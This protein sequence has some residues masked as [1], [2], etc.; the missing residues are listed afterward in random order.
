MAQQEKSEDCPAKSELDIDLV[1]ALY[2]AAGE[3]SAFEGLAQ[4]LKERY[5]FGQAGQNDQLPKA[6]DRQLGTIQEMMQLQA[7][8]P[9]ADPLE[10]AVE[11]VPTPSVVLDPYGKVILTNEGGEGLFQLRPG[12]RFPPDLIDPRYRSQFNSFVASARL[13]GNRRRIVVRLDPQALNL[14][15]H[16]AFPLELA[17][18][19]IIESPKRDNG[20]IALRTMDI[21]WVKTINS[22]LAETFGLTGAEAEVSRDFYHLRDTRTVAEKRGTSLATVQTQLKSIYGK[23]QTAN[24]AE[25]LQMLSLLC[26]RASLDKRSK[27]AAWSNP[28]GREASFIR[29]DGREIAYSWQG[30]EHG[31]PVAVIHGQSMGHIF[32]EEADR[33]YHD[34]GIKLWILSRPGF[35]HSE[36][37]PDIPTMDDHAAAITEFYDHLSIRGAPALTISSGIVGLSKAL[38]ADPGMTSSIAN[39]GYLWNAELQITGR[40]PTYQRVI[41]QMAYNSPRLLKVVVSIAYRNIRKSGVDWYLDKLLSGMQV[42]S[43][44]IASSHNAGLIRAAAEHMLIQGPEVFVRELQQTQDPWV[45][46]LRKLGKPMMFALPE[47]DSIHDFDEYRRGMNVASDT[48]FEVLENSGELYFYKSAE[49]IARLATAHFAATAK[50]YEDVSAVTLPAE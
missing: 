6:I 21:P 30:A 15:E 8:G 10:R 42:D 2:Q 13:R 28:L 22:Q 41:F 31:R 12:D 40:L 7:Q 44:Y 23:T 14:T 20:C 9:S 49:A 24:Q 25:L 5:D 47:H 3:T 43:D 35:G 1:A 36:Y 38:L 46:N 27:L 26:A 34:A 48:A 45:E 17:E 37:N 18:A 32:P 50:G 16:D 39:F 19:M 33:I 4:T 11:E 29:K